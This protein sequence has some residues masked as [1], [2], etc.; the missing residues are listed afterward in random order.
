MPE[1]EIYEFSFEE[2]V[3]PD[4]KGRRSARFAMALVTNVLRFYENTISKRFCLFCLTVLLVAMTLADFMPNE[5][6]ET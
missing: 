6:D 4:K 2:K 3:I 5:S 1:R